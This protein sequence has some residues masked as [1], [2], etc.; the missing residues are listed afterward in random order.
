VKKAKTFLLR[1]AVRKLKD[2]SESAATG[3]ERGAAELRLSLLKAIP[4]GVLAQEALRSRGILVAPAKQSK[5]SPA[6]GASS[7]AEWE[8]LRQQH[9]HVC[10]SLVGALLSSAAVRQLL[11]AA[12]ALT[13]GSR[14]GMP[15]ESGETS[16][17]ADPGAHASDGSA[18]GAGPKKRARP[19]GDTGADALGAKAAQGARTTAKGAVRPGSHTGADAAESTSARKAHT[20]AAGL[21]ASTTVNGEAELAGGTMADVLGSTSANGAHTGARGIK[22]SSTAK[23]AG[24]VK[25]PTA[26]EPSR[27]A[28]SVFMSSLAGDSDGDEDSGD[29]GSNAGTGGGLSMAAGGRAGTGS[30]KKVKNVISRSGNRMGQRQRRALME[31]AAGGGQA[32]GG[33]VGAGRGGGRGIAKA[34]G[35]GIAAGRGR[36]GRGA[37]YTGRGR[38]TADSRRPAGAGPPR[39]VGP[40]SQG[41]GARTSTTASGGALHPSWEAKKAA[42]A[43]IQPFQGKR[44]TFD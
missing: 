29:D 9:S 44:V 26:R 18:A 2:A 38:G 13:P 4:P 41:A 15:G 10:A 43:G 19:A 24:G 39:A 16:A 23:G 17:A 1:K 8:H 12:P 34:G 31:Q 36:G 7:A 35:R 21:K 3:A 37:A 22:A 6:D 32:K 40:P 28:T 33:G 42:S 25:K 27:G 14:S 30:K 11:E 20:G 5:A